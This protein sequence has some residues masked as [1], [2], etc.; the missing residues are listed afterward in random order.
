MMFLR[1]NVA[2]N[3]FPPLWIQMPTKRFPF[4]L[5]FLS[6]MVTARILPENNQTI[7]RCTLTGCGFFSIYKLY[8]FSV[9]CP[10]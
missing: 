3:P 2:P 1:T 8:F 10:P 9:Q 6:A 5:P 4:P 7:S